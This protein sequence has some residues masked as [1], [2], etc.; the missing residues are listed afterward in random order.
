[1]SREIAL[2]RIVRN[3]KIGKKLSFCFNC[4]IGAFVLALLVAIIGFIV[5]AAKYDCSWSIALI[6]VLVLVDDF[7][8]MLFVNSNCFNAVRT[9]AISLFTNLIL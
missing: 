7:I 2:E 9:L 1:M 4:I 3:R 5:T 6:V 8:L